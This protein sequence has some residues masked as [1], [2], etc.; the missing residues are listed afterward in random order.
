MK[1]IFFK[2]SYLLIPILI[3]GFNL[4]LS[5]IEIP[6]T[7]ASLQ[8]E[9]IADSSDVVQI[10]YRDKKEQLNQKNSK[11]FSFHGKERTK[12]LLPIHQDIH[13]FRIDFGKNRVSN[14]FEVKS[15][16]LYSSKNKVDL[17]SQQNEYWISNQ[18]IL[19]FVNNTITTNSLNGMNKAHIYSKDISKQVGLVYGNIPLIKYS[20]LFSTILILALFYYVK[21][22]SIKTSIDLVFIVTFCLIIILPCISSFFADSNNLENRRL[23]AI[24][25]FELNKAFTQTFDR[26]LSENFGMR[27]YILAIGSLIKY[28]LFRS[29][30]NN[31][32]VIIGKKGWFFYNT[33]HVFNS[34]SKRNLLPEKQLHNFAREISERDRILKLRG[35]KYLI[36]FFPNKHVIYKDMLPNFIA[37]QILDTNSRAD[38]YIDFLRK[39]DIEYLD[40]RQELLSAKKS[41]QV[42]FRFDTHWNQHGAFIAYVKIMTALGLKPLDEKEFIITERKYFH[43]DLLKLVALNQVKNDFEYL[44]EYKLKN[45]EIRNLNLSSLKNYPL[46]SSLVENRNSIYDKT[47]VFFCDSYSRNLEYFLT[48]HFKNVYF[49]R[50]KFDDAA[51]NSLKPDYILELLVERDI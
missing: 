18:Y 15:L 30:I 49:I 50:S 34:Y 46:K 33:D 29:S 21:N 37:N 16:T 10:F 19:S 36:G 32:K 38:Q 26:Y 23:E 12:I 20:L 42:Y 41:K 2:G 51:I 28:K 8:L 14:K 31:R 11:R 24:P 44:P 47:L 7:N 35:I 9:F 4:I 22:T 43:G 1:K 13:N 17:L 39:V 6:V 25:K 45:G 5:K 48:I 27:N 40:V 3:L